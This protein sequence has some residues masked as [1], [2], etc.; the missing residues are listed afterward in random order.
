MKYYYGN[1]YKEA[2]SNEPVEIKTTDALRSYE[3][4]YNVVIPVDKVDDIAFECMSF[5]SNF[6]GDEEDERYVE[7]VLTFEPSGD[8][9][10]YTVTET[11]ADMIIE[12]MEKE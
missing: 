6:E 4:N 12:I 11:V 1:S 2:V 9:K 3:E 10:T 8:L 7:V 5:R